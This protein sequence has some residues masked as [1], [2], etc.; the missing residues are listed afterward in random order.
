MERKGGRLPEV[1]VLGL[2]R[3]A[4][5]GFNCDFGVIDDD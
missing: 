2:G 1:G 4:G 3:A 5:L